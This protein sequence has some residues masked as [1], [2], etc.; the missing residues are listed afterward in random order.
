M[1]QPEDITNLPPSMIS[2][3]VESCKRHVAS[4]K[5]RNAEVTSKFDDAVTHLRQI[6]ESYSNHGEET[7]ENMF[8]E[9]LKSQKEEEN[10]M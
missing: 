4:L 10:V 1:L 6:C 3:Q 7:V 2:E 9:V 5:Q 8:I